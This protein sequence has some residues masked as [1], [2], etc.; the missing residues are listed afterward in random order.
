MLFWQA[1]AIATSNLN[2]LLPLSNANK[3]ILIYI[4]QQLNNYLSVQDKR[5]ADLV[6]LACQRDERFAK[7]VFGVFS[8]NTQNQNEHEQMRRFLFGPNRQITDTLNI[9][10]Q[11]EIVAIKDHVD[12]LVRHDNSNINSKV[13]AEQLITLSKTMQLL[14]LDDAAGSLKRAAEE[15]NAWQTPTPEDFDTLLGE[16]MVAENA[17]IFLAKTHTPGA[18]TLPLQNRH[19]SLHQLDT[20]YDTL[21][22]ESRTNIATVSQAVSDYLADP[23]RELMH[24]EHVDDMLRQAAGAAKFLKLTG[25]ANLLTRLARYFE[26]TIASGQKPSEEQLYD[27]ADV[28]MT[29]DYYFEGYEHNRPLGRQALLIGQHSLNRLIAT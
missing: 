2:A 3:L 22:K 29:A 1:A 9:I 27:V 4:E 5:F 26:E 24:L 14:N 20:A 17:A 16:L 25:T 18:I 7:T 11:N 15:V 10:I 28:V 21:I 19:I 23:R 6:G 8:A 13:I 12:A